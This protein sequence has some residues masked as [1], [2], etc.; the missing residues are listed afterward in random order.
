MFANR[1]SNL[2]PFHFV[3]LTVLA[4]LFVTLPETTAEEQGFSSMFNGKNLK[5]W[6]ASENVD[7]WSVKDGMLVCAGPR[8]HLFYETKQPFKNF[9]LKV[10]VMTTPGSNAGI[11]FH[12]T[13]QNEGWPSKGYEVQV[14]VTHGDPKKSGCLY[15]IVDISDPPVKDNVWYETRVVVQDKQIKIWLDG[16]LQVD[17]TEPT[18]KLPN[19][20]Q[21][22]RK[23]SE[24]TFCLQAHDP[25]S[26][27]YF[28]NLRVKRLD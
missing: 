13:F 15:G 12:T 11:Y 25:K 6:K 14:N 8:S 21:P 17:Y 9:E 27:V 4:A 7:S 18:G 1:I 3:L 5:G 19:A 2:K 28:K 20:K 10:D 16:K 23:L 26:V 22:G 24:G